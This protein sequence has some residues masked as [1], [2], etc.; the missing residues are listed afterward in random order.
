MNTPPHPATHSHARRAVEVPP[1]PEHL[2]VLLHEL[3][4][5]FAHLCQDELAVFKLEAKQVGAQLSAHVTRLALFGAI[6]ALSTLPF[7]AF[8]VLALGELFG[9][10]YWLSC[11]LVAIASAA[12][13]GVF[14][15]RSLGTIRKQDLQ[16]PHTVATLEQEKTV[17]LRE[18]EALRKASEGRS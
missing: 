4:T 16:L 11:L 2:S 13:G 12:V 14:A 18:I 7:M 5:A 9:Q 17:L 3:S 1:E 6:L 10:R 15:A 8:L